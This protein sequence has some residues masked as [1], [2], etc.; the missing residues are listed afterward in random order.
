MLPV[1][2]QVFFA[3]L[4]QVAHV[5]QLAHGGEVQRFRSEQQHGAGDGRLAHGGFIE[6]A[7]GL[8]LA[9]RHGALERIVLALDL[10]D[11]ARHL[12]LLVDRGGGNGRFALGIEAADEAD[13]A[14]HVFARVAHE[15]EAGVLLGNAGGDHGPKDS[16]GDRRVRMEGGN[17]WAPWAVHLFLRETM[18]DCFAFHP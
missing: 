18:V 16:D 1:D 2:D 8:D 10:L 12:V 13:A 14:Q 3:R 7:D 4:L 15:V 5:L 9:L 6:V 11:E 17:P